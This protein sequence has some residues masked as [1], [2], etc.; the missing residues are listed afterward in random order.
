MAYRSFVQSVRAHYPDAWIF[1]TIG[2]MLGQDKLDQVTMRLTNVQ[3]ALNDKKLHMFDLGIEDFGADG[4]VPT[5]CDWHPNAADHKRM[6]D[7]L[8]RELKAKLNW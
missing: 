5:G 4:T 7:I 1:L 8:V 2:S 6:S 3:T